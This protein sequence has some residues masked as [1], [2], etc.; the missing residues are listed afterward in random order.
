VIKG[1]VI[2]GEYGNILIR[3]KSG[4][5]V[6]LGE[7]LVGETKDNKILLQVINLLYG[8]QIS[9]QNLELISGMSLEDDEKID[10]MDAELRNYNLA[11]LKNLITISDG[12]A[13]VC[14]RLP[15]F[16]S[17]VREVTK[18]DLKFLTQP[19]DS[20]FVGN[21]R[22]GSKVL[23]VKAYLDGAKAFSHH[24]LIPATTGKGKSNLMSCMLWD[25]LDKDYCS[26]LV[27]D[28]HNEYYDRL[29]NHP[30]KDRLAYYTPKDAP[31]GTK[32]LKINLNL[33]RPQHFNGVV[34]WTQA[35]SEALYAFYSKYG[36]EWIAAIVI[37]KPVQGFNEATITVLKRRILRLLDLDFVNNQLFCNGVFQLSSGESTIADICSELEESKTVIVNTSSFS[38]AVEILIGGLITTEVFGKYRSYNSKGTLKDK[39]VISVVLEEAPRVLGKEVLCRYICNQYSKNDR[40]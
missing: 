8:S 24:I 7:L 23:D 15:A 33:I 9:Q 10:F 30:L 21:L 14:K 20:L 16:F 35:Q 25:S 11:V 37:S 1:Q 31:P 32:T 36:K 26:L 34:E 2:S 6:E 29:K 12:N 28:P 5:K 19:R 40:Y 27:L 3:Q 13:S 39:P 17:S 18:E 4:E 38:G 22:S